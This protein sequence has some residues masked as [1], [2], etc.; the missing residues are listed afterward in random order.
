MAGPAMIEGGGLGV[1]K[2]TDIGPS[3]KQA[4]NGVIDILVE[5]EQ[6]AAEMAKKCLLYFQ[7]KLLE[8]L[9]NTHGAK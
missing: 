6:H 4:K 2:P 5:N 9:K 1:V 3:V 7:G 8:P